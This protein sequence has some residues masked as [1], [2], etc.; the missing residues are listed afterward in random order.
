MAEILKLPQLREHN[1][2]SEVQIRGTWVGTELHT[3][4][5]TLALSARKA[6]LELAAWQGIDDA[7]HETPDI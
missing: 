7:S 5:A 6:L 1:R 2:V 3:K 4:S